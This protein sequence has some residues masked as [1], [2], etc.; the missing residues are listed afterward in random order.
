MFRKNQLLLRS[1][2]EKLKRLPVERAEIGHLVLIGLREVMTQANALDECIKE[3]LPFVEHFFKEL[4]SLPQE[5]DGHWLELLEDMILI[6][7]AKELLSG[8]EATSVA[9]GQLRDFFINAD[10]WDDEGSLV[11]RWYGG[12][13][14]TMISE[15]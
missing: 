15:A 5:D 3:P 14:S 10:E 11:A 2:L 9:E 1:A 6:F 13:F 8:R 7:R 4:Q 12:D